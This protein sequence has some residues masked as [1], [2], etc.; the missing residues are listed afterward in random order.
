MVEMRERRELEWEERKESASSY[1]G[2]M[3][4]LR[5]GCHAVESP[6]EEVEAVMDEEEEALEEEAAVRAAEWEM[7]RV[8]AATERR[9]EL[10]TVREA[11]A[12]LGAI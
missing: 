7:L 4:G 3:P 5:R 2:R 6:A 12:I 9:A 1:A 10:T 8:L 11:E